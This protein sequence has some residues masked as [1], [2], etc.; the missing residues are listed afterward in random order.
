METTRQESF[1]VQTGENE[2]TL[3]RK[4]HNLFQHITTKPFIYAGT[5]HEKVEMYRGNFRIEDRLEERVALRFVKEENDELF[6]SAAGQEPV[7]KMTAEVKDQ[8]VTLSFESLSSL[9]NRFWIRLQASPEEAVYGCGEQL[10]HFN[11]RGKNFPLWTSEPGVGRNKNT[12]VTWQADVTGM[13]GGDY[14]HTNYPQPSF[15]SSRHYAVQVDTTCYADFNFEHPDFHELEVWGVPNRITILGGESLQDCVEKVSDFYG[16]N[17]KL[18]EWVNEG[19]MLGIQGGTQTVDEKWQRAVDEGVHVSALWVQDWQGERITSFGKRLMWNWQWDQNLYPELPAY[20][21]KWRSRGTRFMGYINPYIAVEGA[22]FKEAEAHGYFALNSEGDTYLVD[23]GEFY[24]GV[25]DFTNPEA[26]EWYKQVIKTYLID[27]GLSGWMADFGEYLP[28]DVILHSGQSAMEMHN[29][30]PVLWAKCNHEAI[31]EAGKLDE[32]VFFMRA[33]YAGIQEYCPLLWGG[34]QSVD[35]SVDD[36]IRSVIPAAL[37]AG[38]S[39]MGVHHSDVGGYTSLHGI[40]RSKELLLRWAEMS[41][42]TPVMRSH[43]GNRPYDC[44]QFDDDLETLHHFAK[45]TEW[46]RKLTD[47][48]K[49]VL[50]EYYDKGIPVQRPLLLKDPGDEKLTDEKYSFLLGEDLLVAPVVEEGAV[51]RKVYLP[52][53]EWIHVWTGDRF[54]QGAHEVKAEMGEPPVFYSAQSSWA[55]EFTSLRGD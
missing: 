50:A 35:W 30:W 34:D 46:F 43:E 19:I 24:C 48:R 9:Y 53:G 8:Q 13:A 55:K 15:I 54:S 31:K 22:L 5:G 3:G 40:K 47:Y 1:S 42:F 38:F 6:F 26:F 14:Y 32:I 25:V 39:G 4:G 11:L 37:S 29:H 36:G 44:A 27:F 20:M 7:I 10:S 51:T 41:A 17:P 16:R 33:G 52:K 21:E 45:T 23:F 28:T 12:Y 49:H 18:P 2:W